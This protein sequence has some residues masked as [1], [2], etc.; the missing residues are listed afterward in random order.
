MRKIAGLLA[1]TLCLAMCGCTREDSGAYDRGM[2]ALQRGDYST[3]IDEFQQAAD[4][5]G[6]AAEAYRGEGIAYLRQQDYGHAVT[7]FSLSLDE[8]KHSNQE[9]RRDVLLYQAE[10]Y[11]KNGQSSEAENIYSGLIKDGGDALACVLRG[12]GK[13]KAGDTEGAEED[14]ERALK[15]EN[16]YDTYLEIYQAYTAVSREA[17]GADYLERALELTPETGAELAGQAQVY[18]YLGDYEKAREGLDRAAEEGDSRSLLMLGSL[19][20]ETGE[21]GSARDVYRNYLETEEEPAVAYN[22]LAL[23]DIQDKDYDSA[24]ENIRR[25]I[26]CGDM[27][28]MRDLLYNEIVVYEY[29]MNFETAKTKMKDF[30]EQYPGD[31]QAVRENQFLQSR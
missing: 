21:T 6:R 30:L 7:L 28:A 25:G 19:Y 22:G 24:L 26:D 17:D 4:R 3:A 16:S 2:D 9:F 14:F 23:C 10:A 12:S 5:D 15:Q 11:E 13:L 8:M 1:L 20:L 29:Q 27:E 31:E 18:E